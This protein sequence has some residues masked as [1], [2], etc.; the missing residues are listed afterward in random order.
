MTCPLLLMHE[1]AEVGSRVILDSM[2]HRVGPKGQVVIPKAIRDELGIAPGDEVDFERRDDGVVV[3]GVGTRP[4]LLGV[5]ANV[6]GG[7]TAALM[8][9]RRADR[10]AEKRKAERLG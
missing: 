8:E 6:P 1:E 10:A 9:T 5:L 7:G 3:R 2:T 4:P